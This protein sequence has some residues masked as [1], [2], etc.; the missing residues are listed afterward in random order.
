M[1]ITSQN[2]TL[3][4]NKIVWNVLHTIQT[5]HAHTTHHSQHTK[6]THLNSWLSPRTRIVQI[7]NHLPKK[8][9]IK[10]SHA[11]GTGNSVHIQLQCMHQHSATPTHARTPTH[12]STHQYPTHTHT[13]IPLTPT[14]ISQPHPHRYPS[15]P[16]TLV[17]Q[18]PTLSTHIH[19]H[20]SHTH[21]E[22]KRDEGLVRG[23]GLV[24]P[25]VHALWTNLVL[26]WILAGREMEP[27]WQHD[28]HRIVHIAHTHKYISCR[29]FLTHYGIRTLLHPTWNVHSEPRHG[30]WTTP[31]PS[32]EYIQIAP[33][34]QYRVRN[35]PNP[36]LE[37]GLFLTQD[38]EELH[39]LTFNGCFKFVL[40]CLWKPF[41]HSMCSR[42]VTPCTWLCMLS[43]PQEVDRIGGRKS[44]NYG[45][46]WHQTQWL[47]GLML[48]SHHFAWACLPST[49][50]LIGSISFWKSKM[51]RSYSVLFT[52]SIY[53][54]CWISEEKLF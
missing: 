30:I 33:N 3:D 31:N 49:L 18:P 26:I 45:R 4:S 21:P 22:R 12:T 23:R 43:F 37:Y 8:F 16:H 47:V 41:D 1:C 35:N 46:K 54:V 52:D 40:K 34:C 6:R 28:K 24:Q 7:H 29:P 19:T 14:P 27:L 9:Q 20:S 48:H 39:Q 10:R 44:Q 15:H 32:K 5:V 53:W 50:V 36:S 13:N 11:Y 38:W 2:V 42:Q 25:H 17:S 51:A